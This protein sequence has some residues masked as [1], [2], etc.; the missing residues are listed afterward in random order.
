MKRRI[1][2]N[3]EQPELIVS[4]NWV[5]RHLVTIYGHTDTFSVCASKY[6]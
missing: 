1:L 6:I 5:I 2:I 4:M 3:E